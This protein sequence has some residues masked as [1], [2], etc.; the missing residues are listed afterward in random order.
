MK[1]F[2]IGDRIVNNYI[3]QTDKGY[4]VID[5]GYPGNYAR[6]LRRLQ[7]IGIAASDIRYIFIT[8]VHDDHV[9]FLNELIT[10]TG[11][12]PVMHVEGAERLL[13]GHNRFT[14]GCSG[15]LAKIFVEGMRLAGRGR[16]EFP[17]VK[18]DETSGA[19]LWNG[20][21]QFFRQQGVGLEIIPLPGHTG[22]SIG[23]LTD[24]GILFCGDACMNGF[25][26][27]RRNII[28]IENTER[29]RQSWDAMIQSP[30][31]IIYPSHGAPFPKKDLIRYRKHLDTIKLH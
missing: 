25:P 30:A 23:L 6:F 28:W 5:T 11:A 29:Y 12:T 15:V 31:Q 1:I 21:Q 16:H 3:V 13:A 9:G 26:S 10:E 4:M 17:A 27:I 22:D 2:N 20:E 18:I 19:V 14:G 24:N 7:K 8:H